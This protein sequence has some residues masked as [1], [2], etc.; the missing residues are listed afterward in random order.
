MPVYNGTTYLAEAIDSILS[1]SFR[2]FELILADDGSTDGSRDLARSYVT[3]DRRV[4]LLEL[5]HGGESH[6]VNAAVAAA[7]GIWLARLDQDD[8]AVPER[9]VVQLDW[10]RRTGVDVGGGWARLFGA[11]RGLVGFPASHEAIR[12]RQLFRIGILDST[13]MTRTEI[14]RANP[15]L[16][17]VVSNDYE[18]FSRLV[19]HYRL[20]NQQQVLV[21]RR[22]HREQIHVK[23]HR[24][25]RTDIRHF[26]RRLFFQLFPEAVAA[27]FRAF[28]RA[29]EREP[30]ADLAE[31]ER[32]GQWLARLAKVEERLIRE[33]L[34]GRWRA[35]CIAASGLGPA[36]QRLYHAYAPSFGVETGG[37][38]WKWRVASTL[39]LSPGSPLLRAGRALTRR[40][41]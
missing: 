34:A 27:D 36:S 31:L 25:F 5:E 19:L 4:R 9:F 38:D 10:L 21:R 33:E 18:M 8:V 22:M 16:D 13:L 14:L 37:V 23:E 20:G 39:R 24:A 12:C 3:R 2:D 30:P 11:D 32:A 40:L 35:A 1:Q 6:A 15:Y 29:A 7:R 26:R 17:G 28:D 41:N